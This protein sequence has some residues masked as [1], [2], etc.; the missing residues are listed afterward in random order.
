MNRVS[1]CLASL[2]VASPASATHELDERLPGCYA[3]TE[4][5]QQ[6]AEKYHEAPVALGLQSNG[7]LLTVWISADGATWTAIMTSPRG[8]SCAIAAGESWEEILP[9]VVAGDP[10]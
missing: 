1:V 8:V 6:L 5:A 9:T 3:A 10:T 4:I 7:N 2:L